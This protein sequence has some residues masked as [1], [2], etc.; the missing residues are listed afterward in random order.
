MWES[1]GKSPQEIEDLNTTRAIK[2]TIGE[3]KMFRNQIGQYGLWTVTTVGQ[4]TSGKHFTSTDF[5]I[6]PINILPVSIMWQNTYITL[7]EGIV[8]AK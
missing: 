4:L 5:K 8:S 2:N 3:G 7:I 1:D 6:G